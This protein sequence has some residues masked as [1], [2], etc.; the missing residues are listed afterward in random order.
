M[1]ILACVYAFSVLF[2]VQFIPD[3]GLKSAFSPA[4]KGQPRNFQPGPDGLLPREGDL[5]IQVGDFSVQTWPDLLI[6]PFFIQEKLSS[7]QGTSFPW[8]KKQIGSDSEQ[9]FILIHFE[10]SADENTFSFA[11]WGLL[12]NLPLEDLFPS[13]LWFFLKISLFA[14]GAL[15]LWK[16]PSDAAATQFFLLCIATL[17]AFMGGYHWPYIVTQP[18]LLLVFMVSAIFLPVVSLHFYL[19]FPRK[20]PWLQ[21]QPRQTFLALYGVPLVFLVTLISLYYRLRWLA[22]MGQPADDITALL[23]TTR[24]VTYVYL[25]VASLAYLACV[26]ALFHSYGTAR[27]VTERNQVKWIFFGAVVALLPLSYSLYLTIWNPDA[28]AAGAATW[29]MFTASACLTVAFAVSI[30]RYRLLQLDQIISSGVSYFLISFLA[31]LLYYGVVFVGTLVF[32]QVIASPKL[33]EALAV[34]ATALLLM[35]A[36]DLARARFKKALD[37]RF[38]RDKSQLDKTLQQMGQA[39]QQLVDPPA[40]AQRLLQ[41]ATELL[42]VSRGAIFLREEDPPRYRQAASLGSAPAWP[43]LAADCPLL[44]ALIDNPVVRVPVRLGTALT[45]GQRQLQLLGGELAHALAHEGHLLAVLI[46]GPRLAAS[47]RPEDLGLLAALTQIT[48]LALENAEGHR[49][50]EKLNQDL[51]TKVEKISE[52]QRRILALQGQLR[53]QR[54]GNGPVHADGPAAQPKAETTGQETPPPGGIVGSGPTVR[55]LLTLVRKV[56]STEAVVLIRGAS[57]T[58]KE[59]LARA[60]HETSLRADKPFVKVHCAALSPGLLESELFGHVKGAFTGAHR[61]KVGRFELA[62]TGTLFLDEIGDISLEVQTKLLR[63]LQERTFERVG[64]SEPVSVDVRIITATHQDLEDLIRQ[65][66]FR[67]DLFY[68]LNVFPVV[69]PPLRQ[70]L[71]DIAELALHFMRQSAQRCRKEVTQME[72]DV[73]AVLKAYSWPGNIRQLEN[74][75]ERAVVIAEGAVLTVQELPSEL[76]LAAGQL[77]DHPGGWP[78]VP[79]AGADNG[80]VSASPLRQE[81]DRFEREQL[82]RALAGAG[83]NKAEAA[84][85]LGIARSTLVSRLNKF[86]VN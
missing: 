37:R 2:Y 22:Q 19:I 40:L 79:V 82:L 66:R 11:S 69:V 33:A 9:T 32:N 41:T 35:L 53:R 61:D 13:V 52:Q 7:A 57:G 70:R 85:A 71:E 58:G 51:R 73:L 43:E 25:G 26:W 29:P 64:S 8:V 76:L 46:L 83:G 12:D 20:K 17:C 38:S 34:S 78:V 6:A 18:I 21:R 67:E 44:A 54:L 3:I 42:G 24:N 75:I 81:R 15:V 63:V 86:G 80:A 4:I 47:Y 59:L 74:V 62:N 68:R 28:F 56:A 72:D 55:Q 14:V 45:P 84:R 36:L 39:I 60:V 10:R 49:T 50:M 16:R 1:G 23:Y 27:D 30:T 77:E 65:G 5:V 31:G 48:A